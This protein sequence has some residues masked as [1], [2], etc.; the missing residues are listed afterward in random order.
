[1]DTFLLCIL[2]FV[3]RIFDTSLGTIRTI[4]LIKNKKELASLIA[5]VEILVW[6]LIVKEA[7][8]TTNNSIWVAFS[9]ALGFSTGTYIGSIISEKFLTTTILINAVITKEKNNI[10]KKL[11][12]NN[13]DLSITKIK[14]KDLIS[15]KDMI[16]IVTNSKNIENIKNI[17]TMFD[18]N[19]FIIVNETRKVF[20]GYM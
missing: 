20:N 9:Y 10:V 15:N 18:E 17:I 8:N 13:Y 6:F 4:I 1:M 3:V 16:Y 14:G 11:I 19:A 12:E 2:I 5:L 7:I